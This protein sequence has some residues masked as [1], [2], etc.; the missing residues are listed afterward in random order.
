MPLQ[1]TAEEAIEVA[2][3]KECG[4]APD[5]DTDELLDED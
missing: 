1:G 3:A 4:G 2:I 5:A